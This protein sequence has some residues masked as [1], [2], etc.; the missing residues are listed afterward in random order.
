[1]GAKIGKVPFR[2]PAGAIYKFCHVDLE[3]FANNSRKLKII[4]GAEFRRGIITFLNILN[5]L[6]KLYSNTGRFSRCVRFL[7]TAIFCG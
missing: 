7:G 3:I 2:P 1:M 6:H 4:F 5:V